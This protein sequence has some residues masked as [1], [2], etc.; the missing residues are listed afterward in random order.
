M[1]DIKS[2]ALE[3]IE[4][5]DQEAARDQERHDRERHESRLAD[6]RKR[7]KENDVRAA[8]ERAKKEAGAEAGEVAR[9][10]HE[11]E[12]LMEDQAEVLNRSIAELEDLDRRHRDAL[13]RAGRNPGHDNALS[14]FLPR[15]FAHRFGGF[16][17]VTG[18]PGAHPAGKE[19]PLPERDPLADVTGYD[20]EEAS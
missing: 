6:A 16:G 3:L 5:E 20:D 11:L 10:R 1:T 9:E 2:R 7:I 4:R 18:V 17:S 15:W 12:L 8:A 14:G 19:R 13:R